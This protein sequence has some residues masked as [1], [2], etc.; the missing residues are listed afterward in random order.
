MSVGSQFE[1]ELKKLLVAR[2]EEIRDNLAEGAAVK[3]FGDYKRYVG[4][5]QA[6]KLVG[7]DMINQANEK[8]NK[9]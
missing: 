3:D 8:V 1:F 7:E 6:L 9:R 2:M 5:Y 4:E